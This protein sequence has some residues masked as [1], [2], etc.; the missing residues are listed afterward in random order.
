MWSNLSTTTSLT[1]NGARDSIAYREVLI[2]CGFNHM[3]DMRGATCFNH[4]SGAKWSN[5]TRRQNVKSH[6]GAK[7][8]NHMRRQQ[9]QS[10]VGRQWIQ[11]HA[12]PN[13]QITCRR[14]T[15]QSHVGAKWSNH[16]SGAWR[17][18]NMT[19]AFWCLGPGIVGFGR[20]KVASGPKTARLHYVFNAFAQKPQLSIAKTVLFAKMSQK[21]ELSLDVFEKCSNFTRCFL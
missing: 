10:H 17:T 3:T 1:F 18:L 7:Q 12:A 4:M 15:V 13:A 8:Y 14:Q 19:L 16:M 21:L 20:S 5:H 9:L 6:V 11:S 2:T